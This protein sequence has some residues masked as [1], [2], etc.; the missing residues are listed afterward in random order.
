M[1]TVVNIKD[2]DYT[3][4]VGRYKTYY[5]LPASKFAN[6][7]KISNTCTRKESVAKFKEYFM[8]NEE[9][10]SAAIKE[11]PSNA[12]LACWCHPLSCHAD[13]IAQFINS[14]SW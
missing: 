3:I 11:I 9:L 14:W 6:P 13:I 2:S 7:F 10:K 4:Y 8:S 1:V 12:I 5:N